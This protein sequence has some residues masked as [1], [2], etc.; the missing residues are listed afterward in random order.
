[1]SARSPPSSLASEGSRRDSLVTHSEVDHPSEEEYARPGTWPRIC[2][3]CSALPSRVLSVFKL[4]NNISGR[5]LT[6]CSDSTDA[7][8]STNE[9]KIPLES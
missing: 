9:N 1:M 4:Q 8:E 7:L 2:P 3:S 6:K 5:C